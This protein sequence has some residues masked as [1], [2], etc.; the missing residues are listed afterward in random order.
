MDISDAAVIDHPV[1]QAFWG[2][3]ELFVYL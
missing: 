1:R 2:V 3:F